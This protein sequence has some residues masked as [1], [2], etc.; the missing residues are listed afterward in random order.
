MFVLVQVEG[1]WDQGGRTPSVWDVWS[2]TPG[3]VKNNDNGGWA[4]QDSPSPGPQPVS[5]CW[6]CVIIKARG[7]QLT[8]G[9]GT[10]LGRRADEQ[11]MQ[12][13]AELLLVVCR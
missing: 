13:S 1:A 2:H 3:K 8:P 12:Q 11:A 9:A 4:L 6:P 7:T 10:L 5:P